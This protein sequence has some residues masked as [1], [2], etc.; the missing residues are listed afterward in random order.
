MGW[1]AYVMEEKPEGAFGWLR[2]FAELRKNLAEENDDLA[3]K[4]MDVEFEGAAEAAREAGWTGQFDE[5]SHVFVL[6]AEVTM[7]FGLLWT[8]PDNDFPD[9]PLV[10]IISPHALPW[11]GEPK[12][13][14]L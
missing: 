5:E 4:Q 7:Q 8:Q 11:L 6:P 12:A 13:V 1:H 10:F 9:E 3:C 14:L 2:S